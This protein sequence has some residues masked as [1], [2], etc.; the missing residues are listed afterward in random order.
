M[1]IWDGVYPDAEK[2]EPVYTSGGSVLVVSHRI[3]LSSR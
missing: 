3:F 2:L 1:F